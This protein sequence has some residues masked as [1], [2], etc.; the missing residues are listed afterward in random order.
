[1]SEL[2]T[3]LE[4]SV[5]IDQ[6]IAAR[7]DWRAT[8]LTELRRLIHQALPGVIEEVKWGNVPVWSQD[9]IICT[10]ETYKKVVKLTFPHGAALAD[11]QTLFNASLDGKVRRAIDLAEGQQLDSQAFIALI[12]AAATYNHNKL[13]AKKT[14]KAPKSDT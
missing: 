4:P 12:Q 5:R 11:P 9:G 1:M 6:L 3:M 2:P 7:A 10:G 8:T 13:L 14:T